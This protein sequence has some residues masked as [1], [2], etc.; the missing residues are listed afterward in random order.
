MQSWC[1]TTEGGQE[2]LLCYIILAQGSF[3]Y[4]MLIFGVIPAKKA[5]VTDV[6]GKF[7]ITDPRTPEP[8]F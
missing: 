5:I 2:I 3:R 1:S 6:Y 8:I 4:F 7:L